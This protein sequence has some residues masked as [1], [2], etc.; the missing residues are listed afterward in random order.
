[1]KIYLDDERQA[2]QGYTLYKSGEALLETIRAK[3]ELLT[4]CEEIS[5]D[6]QLGPMFSGIMT[7]ED[8][9]SSLIEMHDAG[10]ISL[11]GVRLTVHS[12]HPTK[13]REMRVTIRDFRWSL[14][15]G[16]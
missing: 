1:M 3:P 9:L 16:S 6:Y 8:V 13:A 7:G 11:K 15:E 5:L 10:L 12:Q 4:P 14:K 2:P